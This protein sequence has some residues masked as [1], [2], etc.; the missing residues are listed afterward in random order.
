MFTKEEQIRRSKRNLHYLCFVAPFVFLAT[1]LSVGVAKF[2]LLWSFLGFAVAGL[3][4]GLIVTIVGFLVV[5][6]VTH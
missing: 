5:D 6:S 2:I 1:G 4:G 3:I